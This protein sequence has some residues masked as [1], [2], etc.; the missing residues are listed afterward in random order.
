[1]KTL[2]DIVA[3]NLIELRKSKHLTQQELAEK[4]AYSDKTIS[5]WELGYAIPSVEVLKQLGDFYG[6]T[7]DYF[8]TEGNRIEKAKMKKKHNADDYRKYIIAALFVSVVFLIATTIFVWGLISNQNADLWTAFVWAVPCSFL[9]L[10]L[11]S[12]RWWRSSRW[13]TLIISSLL[14]WTIITAFYVQFLYLNANIWYIYFIGAP[15]EVVLILINQ[16]N[17]H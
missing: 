10:F 7:L 11:C 6:V 16:M 5:K 9:A 12:L 2:N 17:K 14:V 3:E 15:V 8:I 13:T 4:F 1:M